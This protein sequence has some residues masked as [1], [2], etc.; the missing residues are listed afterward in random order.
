MPDNPKIL[1][2]DDDPDHPDQAHDREHAER[3]T[4]LVVAVDRADEPEGNDRHHD[5]RPAVRTE[6]PGQ[7]DVDHRQRKQC[8]ARHVAGRLALVFGATLAYLLD[9]SSRDRP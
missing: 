5:Q 1:V 2:V 9:R 4:P 7:H 8:A 6:H 3:D